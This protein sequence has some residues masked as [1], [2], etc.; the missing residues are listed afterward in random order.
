MGRGQERP[1]DLRQLLEAHYQG[2]DGA[3]ASVTK[4]TIRESDYRSRAKLDGARQRLRGL[5]VR[6]C[7]LLSRPR[8]VS[9]PRRR[10]LAISTVVARL[11]SRGLELGRPPSVVLHGE[12][13]P[14]FRPASSSPLGKMARRR[15]RPDA[16]L[17]G[18]RHGATARATTCEG[19]IADGDSSSS[20]EYCCR[21]SRRHNALTGQLGR[22]RSRRHGH[23]LPADLRT[24]WLMMGG[25]AARLPPSTDGGVTWAL[26]V[27]S[28]FD[29]GS[30]ISARPYSDERKLYLSAG[31][32]GQVATSPNAVQITLRPRPIPP[33]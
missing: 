4:S 2:A 6:R 17:D 13:F 28:P 25:T 20:G 7:G 10:N 24:R 21:Q 32:G 14:V 29:S 31:S 26:L 23:R 18:A 9:S 19:G 33:G 22:P 16:T 11:R 8:Y 15:L 30:T 1:R 27:P 3:V 5:A 12:T